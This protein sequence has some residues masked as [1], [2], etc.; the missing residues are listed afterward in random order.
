MSP[1]SWGTS[2]ILLPLIV[3]AKRILQKKLLAVFSPIKTRVFERKYFRFR[4]VIHRSEK[5]PLLTSLGSQRSSGMRVSQRHRDLAH[6][7]LWSDGFALQ[8]GLLFRAK[9]AVL[10]R[11]DANDF[12]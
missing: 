8:R 6:T 11:P 3:A 12:D 2:R 10:E 5:P 9:P 4:Q 7:G 1:I